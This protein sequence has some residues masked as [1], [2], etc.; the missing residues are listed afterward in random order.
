MAFVSAAL[1]VLV[2]LGLFSYYL[3][4]RMLQ[5][6]F[7]ERHGCQAPPKRA[8]QDPIL[9]IDRKLQDSKLSKA[10][11][12]LPAGVSLFHTYGQT[13]RETTILGTVIKT[14]SA[15]NI[16][17][18]HGLKAKDWGIQLFR[19]PAM[20]PFCGKGFITTDGSIWEH[21]RAL[22]K[23]SFH[24]GNI[25]DL[26]AFESSVNQFLSGIPT[27]GSTID[28]QPRLSLLVKFA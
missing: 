20:N 5:N 18:I 19:L 16:H 1:I 27:D 12:S 4:V 21:S 22:L 9:G 3:R 26:T 13:F 11:Q 23:P 25:S 28:L 15:E 6:S 17:T 10:F 24:K 14:K 7:A 2:V 8:A